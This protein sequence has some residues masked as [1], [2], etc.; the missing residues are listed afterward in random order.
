[1]RY[2]YE[3]IVDVDTMETVMVY[4]LEFRYINSLDEFIYGTLSELGTPIRINIK[5]SEKYYITDIYVV[6]KNYYLV[7]INDVTN[8]IFTFEV[9][10][11]M[12]N[13]KAVM[14]FLTKIIEYLHRGDR[15]LQALMRASFD[16]EEYLN[17][18][19]IY[20]TVRENFYFDR[21]DDFEGA[22]T[23]SETRRFLSVY[24][25][26]RDYIKYVF[27]IRGDWDES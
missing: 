26:R 14:F 17:C 10:A 11:Y 19:R 5:D 24:D 2:L 4:G 25:T 6:N 22:I 21:Y 16:L 20:F 13:F 7:T 12:V 1:M 27:P 15:F 8:F 18:K 9:G 3:V 23:E